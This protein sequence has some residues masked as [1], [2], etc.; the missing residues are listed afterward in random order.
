MEDSNKP[1]SAKDVTRLDND[2]KEKEEGLLDE[3]SVRSIECKPPTNR[4][5]NDAEPYQQLE[6]GHGEWPYFTHDIDRGGVAAID[7]KGSDFFSRVPPGSLPESAS[8]RAAE[9]NEGAGVLSP[10]SDPCQ[11][12]SVTFH[13]LFNLS[14]PQDTRANITT[15]TGH[16]VL[17]AK[18]NAVDL[19]SRPPG[20]SARSVHRASLLHPITSSVTGN[21]RPAPSA[22]LPHVARSMN[23]LL[24]PAPVDVGAEAFVSATAR[25]RN[26]QAPGMKKQREPPQYLQVSENLTDISLQSVQSSPHS[27]GKAR[28]HV[29]D[30]AG[31]QGFA[32]KSAKRRL[33]ALGRIR[34]RL[35]NI[36]T[37]ASLKE[38][39]AKD[40]QAGRPEDWGEARETLNKLKQ[41]RRHL[42]LNVAESN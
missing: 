13:D 15:G 8:R 22:P 12:S 24:Q 31:S 36:V 18:G 40:L 1:P 23:P 11:P 5:K 14:R 6:V 30:H 17:E 7:T 20:F 21:F 10:H 32:A 29:D 4:P 37:V 34:E 42:T 38:A 3:M 27:V 35:S 33:L 9:L 26:R 28:D 16:D 2:V 19:T 41:L 25:T 39:T